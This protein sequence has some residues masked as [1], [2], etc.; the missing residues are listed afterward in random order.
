MKKLTPKTM[1]MILALGV[2]CIL[3]GILFFTARI[4]A[5]LQATIETWTILFVV[6][7]AVIFYFSLTVFK[8]SILFFTGLFGVLSGTAF[9]IMSTGL[10]SHGFGE[11]WPVSVIIASICLLLTGV[12][13]DRSVHASFLFP[14]LVMAVL[15]G[16]FLLF[17]LDVIKMSFS[18]FAAYWWP[19]VPLLTGATIVIIYILQQRPET[20]KF[21]PYDK[22]ENEDET[23]RLAEGDT[24]Q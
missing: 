19:I 12:A 18:S 17:S 2:L 6:T 16:L 14:S 21:F 1:N 9:M 7:G 13:K 11:L 24:I 5:P 4:A 8:Y 22:F 20:N 10:F 3:A 23:E 15:G